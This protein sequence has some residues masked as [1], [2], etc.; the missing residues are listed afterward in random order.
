[1]GRLRKDLLGRGRLARA[2]RAAFI[3][4]D[5]RLFI[6]RCETCWSCRW[7]HAIPDEF[8]MVLCERPSVVV[9]EAEIGIPIISFAS[10]SEGTTCDE[11]EFEED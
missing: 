6:T 4:L 1:M 8:E 5:R 10:V 7:H 2:L 9:E 11:F 3:W